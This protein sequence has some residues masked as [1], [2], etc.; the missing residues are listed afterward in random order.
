MPGID[1]VVRIQGLSLQRGDMTRLIL[2]DAIL[3]DFGDSIPE[4]EHPDD[5]DGKDTEVAKDIAHTV[6][7]VMDHIDKYIDF[8][9]GTSSTD[10]VPDILT[11]LTGEDE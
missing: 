5:Y 1:D 3:K 7:L 6:G 9:N 11:Y 4:R 8:M 10:E 2:G